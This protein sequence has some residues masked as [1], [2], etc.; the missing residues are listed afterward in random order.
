MGECFF[1]ILMLLDVSCLC[2]LHAEHGLP[3]PFW[4]L[5]LPYR[6]FHKFTSSLVALVTFLASP[7]PS[8]FHQY[9]AWSFILLKRSQSSS[10]MQEWKAKVC[11]LPAAL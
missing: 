6:T 10:L 1:G 5:T 8:H 3:S 4:C 11:G 9:A 2:T 7:L